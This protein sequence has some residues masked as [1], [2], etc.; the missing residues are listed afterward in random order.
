MS[1][2]KPLTEEQKADLYMN[3]ENQAPVPRFS[4]RHQYDYARDREEGDLAITIIDDPS[5]TQQHF[6]DDAN[7]N[8]IMKRYGVTDG[9]I[10]PAAMDPRFFGDFTD[11]VDFREALDRVRAA[12]EHFNALPADLR[13][14][15]NNDPVLLHDWVSSPDNWEEAVKLG[16]LRKDVINKETNETS[17]GNTK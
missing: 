1:G 14:Q 4:W 10:P 7:L 2:R 16:L 3:V 12:T 8:T 13:A 9:A 11:A 5:L 6:A 17:T 15:F